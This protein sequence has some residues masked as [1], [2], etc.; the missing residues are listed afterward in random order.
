M[1]ETLKIGLIVKPQGIKGELKVQPLT[2]DINRFRKLKEV[3]IDDKTYKVLNTVIG[4]NVVFISI[5]GVADRNVAE[6]FRGKFLRVTRENAIPLEEG[7]YFVV[8]IIGCE[9]VTDKGQEVGKVIEVTSARTDVFTLTCPNGK[10]MRF[11]FLNDLVLSVD[12]QNK[13]IT[14]SEKRL[15]EVSCYED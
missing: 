5:N 2:D 8:D 9:V 11:P 1:V 15:E 14:V 6:S 13:K 7:R 4:G 10:I 12:V 3:I